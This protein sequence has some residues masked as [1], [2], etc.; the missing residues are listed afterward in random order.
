MIRVASRR[1]GRSIVTDALIGVPDE[2]LRVFTS[3]FITLFRRRYSWLTIPINGY[4][5]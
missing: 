3:S 1:A 2:S 5:M 4:L